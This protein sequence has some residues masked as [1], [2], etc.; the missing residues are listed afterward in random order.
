MILRKQYTCPLELTHDMMK[1]KW[2]PI[3]L[4]RLRLGPT[5]LAKLE[6]DIEGITQK[7][8][9]EQLKELITYGL[10]DKKTYEGFPLHVEYFLTEER[11]QKMLEALKIMQSVGIDYMMKNNMAD[12]LREKGVIL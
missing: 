3:I 8:L 4:W 2:K 10:V 1:G 5:S 11:G 12:V 7:M 9:L 6:K